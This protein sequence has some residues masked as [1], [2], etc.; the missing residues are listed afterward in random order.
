MNVSDA[1]KS[2]DMNLVSVGHGLLEVA[3]SRMNGATEQL[4][5]LAGNRKCVREK[6]NITS[7]TLES[8]A[9]LLKYRS[10]TR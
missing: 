10:I 4:S 9:K 6:R 7:R 1:I 3:R 2:G 5:I 8:T